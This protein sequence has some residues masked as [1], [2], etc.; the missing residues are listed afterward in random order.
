MAESRDLPAKQCDIRYDESGELKSDVFF[1]IKVQYNPECVHGE[2]DASW[3]V[4]N[5]EFVEDPLVS[6]PWVWVDFIPKSPP[7]VAFKS[8]H[9]CSRSPSHI[10][11]RVAVPDQVYVDLVGYSQFSDF[12]PDTLDVNTPIVLSDKFRPRLEASGLT[13][14]RS[15]PLEIGVNQSLAK[16]PK[17]F[18]LEFTG[19]IWERPRKVVGKPNACPHC[20]NAPLICPECGY[21][22]FECGKCNKVQYLGPVAVEGPNDIRLRSADIPRQGRILMGKTWTGEDFFES[23]RAR[24]IT[25]RA[26][27]WLLM[28]HAKPFYARPARVA[29]EGMSPEQLQWLND[30]QRLPKSAMK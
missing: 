12:V 20:G 1:E 4:V 24:Y 16:D 9:G 25:K 15:H 19:T 27:D 5:L 14:I 23:R 28:V 11:R 21:E 29:V 8:L 30:A 13:G 6:D 7:D 2:P 18:L 10:I 3:Y 17:L 22:D 26:L